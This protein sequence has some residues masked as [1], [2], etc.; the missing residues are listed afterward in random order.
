VNRPGLTQRTSSPPASIARG[1][2]ASAREQALSM[3][4]YVLAVIGTAAYVVMLVGAVLAGRWTTLAITSAAYLW[5]LAVT[6]VRSLPLG[7]RSGTLLA[8]SFGLALSQLLREGLAGD[9]RLMLLAFLVIASLLTGRRGGLAALILSTATLGLI[10]WLMSS[11]RIPLPA[12]EGAAE[13]ASLV[14]WV[15]SGAVFLLLG[16]IA[17]LSI[18]WFVRGIE[19]ALGEQGGLIEQVR[20]QQARLEELVAARTRDLERQS[21][22][23]A[24]A[25][26]IA[27]LAS[28]EPDPEGLMSKAIELIRERFDFYHASVFLLD[29]GK[30][31]AVMAASTG[32]AGRQLLARGHRLAVGSASIVGWVTS[33][34]MPRVAADVE[35]D[36]FHFRNPLLPGTRSEMAVPVMI[37]DRLIGA[38]DVQSTQPGAFGEADVRAIEVISAEL[39]IAFE[40]SRLLHQARSGLQGTIQRG[41]AHWTEPWRKLIGA[42]ESTIVHLEPREGTGGTGAATSAVADEAIR[43]GAP[44][45]SEDRKELAV[46][47]QV[48]GE[49]VATIVARRTGPGE[50]WSADDIAIVQTIAGQAALALE[51]ARQY[52]EEQ[53]RLAELELVNRVSQAASQLVNLD[54]LYRI[55][56]SQLGRVMGSADLMIALYDAASDQIT[57]PFLSKGGEIT[58]LEATPLGEGL[59]S[60]VVRS[61]QPLLLTEDIEQAAAALGARLVGRVPRCWLGVPMLL[62]EEILGVMVVQDYESERRFTDDDTALLFTIAS[63]VA[64]AVENS[65]L[66]DQIR[67]SERRQRL[68][69]EITAKV[70]RASDMDTILTTAARE[71]S[72][73]LNANRASARLGAMPAVPMPP[74]G[75]GEIPEDEDGDGRAPEEGRK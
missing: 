2:L 46:P 69:R 13:S 66:L 41:D 18:A 1:G 15:I 63:Q 45:T 50:E 58:R 39:A 11:G 59:L 25:G 27:K 14:A 33:N 72:V 52:A 55:V 32:E 74:G 51:G 9:G 53:R 17:T 31:W 20:E 60:V 3:L 30:L 49:V 22:E 37:G 64:A 28:T 44:A 38:L 57:I 24:T 5:L 12:G 42:E 23:L 65:R 21:K 19:A 36:P 16:G 6:L 29:E 7:L 35:L 71:L 54:S 73:E 47:I 4:Y 10:G 70:R 34:R 43:S 62:A 8:A 68:I 75:P 61:K 40:N 26:E 48:R 67:R 56:H